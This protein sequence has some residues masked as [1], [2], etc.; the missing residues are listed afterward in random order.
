MVSPFPERPLAEW[1]GWARLASVHP[2]YT[3]VGI[4]DVWLLVATVG[5]EQFTLERQRGGVRQFA[6]VEAIV[7]FIARRWP[8]VEKRIQVEF[9]RRTKLSNH[10]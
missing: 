3:A 5:R 8:D 2:V 7:D 6:S 10:G 9:F 4:A 1:D